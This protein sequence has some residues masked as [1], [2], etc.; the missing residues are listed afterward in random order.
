MAQVFRGGQWTTIAWE[1]IVVGDIVKIESRNTFHAIP[2]DILI[3]SSSE[4]GGIAYIET[5]SLDGY[6]LFQCC[7]NLFYQI[8]R[9]TNL[10]VRQA[11]PETSHISTDE[12]LQSFEATIQVF[13]LFLLFVH[14]CNSVNFQIISCIISTDP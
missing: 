7:T 13:L 1:K 5:S 11:L 4:S 6:M 9:E 2:A 8:S 3:I 12:L 14:A 10:K